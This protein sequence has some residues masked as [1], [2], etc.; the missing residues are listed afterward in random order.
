MCVVPSNRTLMMTSS[1]YHCLNMSMLDSR[2]DLRPEAFSQPGD[3]T[4]ILTPNSTSLGPDASTNASP[5]LA[6]AS[7]S[8]LE[9]PG[10]GDRMVSEGKRKQ[11]DDS[12]TALDASMARK[13]LK[14][15]ASDAEEF[16]LVR[17]EAVSDAAAAVDNPANVCDAL[18]PR[19][20]C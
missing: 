13:K 6:G 11:E 7:T 3:V 18:R 14:L 10:P 5:P 16:P 20:H 17:S 1:T 19:H 2:P 15:E 9:A 8:T 4:A 12:E